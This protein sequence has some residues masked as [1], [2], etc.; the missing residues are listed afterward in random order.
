MTI[1]DSL[2]GHLHRVGVPELMWREAPPH[3]RSRRGPP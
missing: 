1:S 2:M 3:A